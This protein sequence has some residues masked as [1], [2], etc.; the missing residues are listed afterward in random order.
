MGGKDH[1]MK[2]SLALLL[3]ASTAPAI[4]LTN[5]GKSSYTIV[6][7]AEA[8]PSEHRAAH[9]L[10]RFLE[11][12]S[13]ARLPI[14]TDA[15]PHQ[16]NLILLGDSAALRRLNPSIPYAQLGPEG[17]VLQTTGPHFI[18]AGGRQRGTMY[19]VYTFLDKLGC[20]WFTTEVSRIPK[21]PTIHF[22]ALKETHR[23]AFEYRE[24]FFTEAWDKDWAARNRTNGDHSQLD[25]STGGKLQYYPFVHSFYELLPPETYF[26]DHPEYFSL[27]DGKRRTER[28]QLCL[29]NAA[30]LKIAIAKVE[31]W[32]KEHPEATIFSVSQNDWEGW[33][34]CDQCRRV[35][36]EEGGQHSGPLLRFVNAVANEIG[37][38]HPGK[39]IDTLAYWYT[40]NPPL[41][42]RPAPNVRI[43][44]CPIGTCVAHSFAQCPR[45][46]YF[47]R[48][49]QSWS[50]ITNQL[51][52]WHYNTNFSHYLM[53]FPDFDELA[54]DI[55][56]YKQHGVVGLFL[57]GAYGKGVA[58]EN[59][60]LRAYVLARQLWDPSTN[61]NQTVDEFLQGVYGPAAK[62]LRAYFDLLHSEVRPP[63]NRHLWIFNVPEYSAQFRTQA[64]KLF[65]EAVSLAPDEATRRRV[66]KARLPIEY[67]ALLR[68][69]EFQLRG[70]VYGP[71]DVA[72][73]ASRARDLFVRLRAFGI[74]SIHEGQDLARDEQ[75]YAVMQGAPAITLENADWRAV[76]VPALNARLIR[77]INKSTG[78]DALRRYPPGEGGYPNT[79]GQVATLHAGYY[80][81]ACE[82]PWKVDTRSEQQ[83]TLT[84]QCENGIQIRR[85]FQLTPT[86]LQ[87]ET[88]ATNQGASPVQ[89]ALQLRADFATPVIDNSRMSFQRL[90][91]ESVDTR[92]VV[93]GAEPTGKITWTGA[94]RP[95]SEWRLHNAD[96]VLSVRF[97]TPQTGRGFLNWTAKS[98]SG[99]TFGLWSPERT[100]APGE[101]LQLD[102]LYTPLTPDARN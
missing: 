54:A 30:V 41:Y 28:G 97:N 87:T 45:S 86:G 49:L 47:Y 23:P 50:K 31:T 4:T 10:Q 77:L 57:Q 52:I 99:V 72:R 90:N 22:P 73:L 39:L 29:T 85:Q 15:Q 44:L 88:R 37:Q 19:G 69:T 82:A 8:S 95:A 65:D 61:V 98:T 102:S 6:L 5:N 63:A 34:E 18:I 60:E 78:Q 25:A 38:R 13:G 36:A 35:E 46:Q 20:R 17:F 16:G 43:R 70:D 71:A 84:A 96:S 100:L 1:I 12:I 66:L 92:F 62:P 81:K 9:E 67:Y 76:I 93:E 74:E 48:N 3:L 79:G 32:I 51:Y 56:L 26:K 91:G 7:A 75:R 59:S 21:Q 68:D 27:I 42:V 94:D 55:P 101:S 58:G 2:K 14:A 89:A 11:E 40:E 33:C 64:G 53:P 24:P 80:D 83:L